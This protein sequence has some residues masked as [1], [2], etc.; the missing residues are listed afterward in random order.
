MPKRVH[1]NDP[2]PRNLDWEG[3]E[4]KKFGLPT[5]SCAD[6]EARLDLL[7][8]GAQLS[9]V[10]ID[11]LDYLS[12]GLSDSAL[13]TLIGNWSSMPSYM[14]SSDNPYLFRSASAPSMDMR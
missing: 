6:S 8:E 2:T 3:G 7:I 9:G 13:R 12:Q 14:K 11:A 1:D 5:E 4:A 10:T